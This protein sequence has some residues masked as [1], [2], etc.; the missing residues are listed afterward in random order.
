MIPVFV[1]GIGCLSSLSQLLLDAVDWIGDWCCSYRLHESVQAVSQMNKT[2]DMEC[3]H[4][5]DLIKVYICCFSLFAHYLCGCP[6]F[7]VVKTVQH[8]PL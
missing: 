3:G 5:K 6:C 7:S 4:F 8:R 2:V 1:S